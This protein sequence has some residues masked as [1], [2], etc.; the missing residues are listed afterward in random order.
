MGIEV[1]TSESTYMTTDERN[2]EYIKNKKKRK[3]TWKDP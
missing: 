1:K 2:L 3:K